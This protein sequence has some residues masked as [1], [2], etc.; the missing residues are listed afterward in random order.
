MIPFPATANDISRR[1][2]SVADI[3]LGQYA[4]APQKPVGD[5]KRV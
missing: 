1:A 5:F 3:D 2:D 4:P